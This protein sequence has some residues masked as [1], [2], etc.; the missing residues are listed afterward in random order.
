MTTDEAKSK[1]WGLGADTI[2]TL[3]FP[4]VVCIAFMVFGY[5]WFESE[6][7]EACANQQYIRETLTDLVESTALVIERNTD[8][9]EQN[10][11]VMDKAII[12]LDCPEDK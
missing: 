9:F 11:I 6:R 5:Q 7:Q 8:A 1:L 3:G 4:I 2:K 10:T 12:K